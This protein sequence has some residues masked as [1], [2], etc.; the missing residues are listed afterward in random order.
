[1]VFRVKILE[2]FVETVNKMKGQRHQTAQTHIC[3]ALCSL[4]KVPQPR[5]HENGMDFFTF[6]QGFNR[7]LSR[8]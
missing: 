5:L 8:E 3:A 4:L 2:Q 6:V 7:G 1:M